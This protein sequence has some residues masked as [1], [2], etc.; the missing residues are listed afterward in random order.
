MNRRFNTAIC[1]A[2]I[3]LNLQSESHSYLAKISK[4]LSR[5]DVTGFFHIP[6]PYKVTLGWLLFLSENSVLII[7]SYGIIAMM[8]MFLSKR[9]FIVATIYFF[10]HICDWILIWYDYKQSDTF[11]WFMQAAAISAIWMAFK[12][13]KEDKKSPVFRMYE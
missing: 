5:R 12:P 8:A 3:L 7:F 1:I 13:M 2:M 11:Y 10:Y 6:P 9:L 4:T